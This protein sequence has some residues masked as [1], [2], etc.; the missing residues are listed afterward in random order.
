MT[1]E[2]SLRMNKLK[3]GLVLDDSLD[4][5]DGVQQYVLIAGRWL[6]A[7]GHEVHYL[8]G[9]TKRTDVPNLHSLARNVKV[10][11]NQNRMAM[12]LPA[13]ARA[14]R[15]LLQ[16]EQFDVLHV[17]VP[18]SPLLAGRII[19]AADDRT[20]VV[21]TFHILPHSRLVSLANRAL[22]R[23]V[24]GSLRRFD[25]I[26]SN[27]DATARFAKQVF[28]ATGPVIPLP[29]EL[30][31]FYGAKPFAKYKTGQTVLFLGR[32]VER[33]GCQYLLRAVAAAVH[34]KTWPQG[35]RVVICGDGHMRPELEK[36]VRTHHL[37]DIVEFVGY[38]SEEDKPRYL[39]SADVVAY[40]STG[41]EGFGLVLLEAMA[42]SPGVVLAGNNP[43][44][45]S[46]MAPRPSSLFDPH[47]TPALAKKLVH[48]LTDKPTRSSARAWQREYVKE[49][50]VPQIGKRLLA[51]Y[52]QALHKRRA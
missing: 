25:V 51:L 7:Q 2:V 35:T 8:V 30:G 16:R 14:I 28:G 49:F 48:S 13:N 19:Q 5:P 44:Y 26:T 36:Y 1:T 33:K 39:A 37:G 9:Q 32:L 3:I 52:K 12:P 4:K 21:G 27:T 50:D 15:D 47:D 38:I 41:G 45:A 23:A 10:R 34:D 29:V 22:S 42:A 6:A 40:P 11:F 43:G 46:A 31:R 18:Y 20:A 17:Q 24:R